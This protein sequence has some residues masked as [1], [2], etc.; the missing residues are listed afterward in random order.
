MYDLLPFLCGGAIFVLG[1]LMTV[2]P[3]L[4]TKKE[5]RDDPAAV[6]KVRKGGII[7][8]ICGIIICILAFLRLR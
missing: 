1:I 2:M 4:M 3:K 8:I 6:A 7:E 5:M